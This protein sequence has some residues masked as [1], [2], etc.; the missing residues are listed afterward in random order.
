LV[1]TYAE[2]NKNTKIKANVLCPKAVNTSF[3]DKIMPGENKEDIL[4][5]YTVAMKV[6]EL[7]KKDL[8]E[9]GKIFNI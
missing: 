3:R 2:E 5:V 9:T 6:I 8:S 4:S 7:T 1:I